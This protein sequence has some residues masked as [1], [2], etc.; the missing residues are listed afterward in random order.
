MEGLYTPS[1]ILAIDGLMPCLITRADL[2]MGVEGRRRDGQ[3]RG[4]LDLKAHSLIAG[5]L[6]LRGHY[7][8]ALDIAFVW[9]TCGDRIAGD[10]LRYPH[11]L[12]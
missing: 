12:T 4:G 11:L 1:E 10:C 2:N 9:L 8:L 5:S 6:D 7:L 3:K